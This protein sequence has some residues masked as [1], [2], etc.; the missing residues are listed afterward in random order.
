[1]IGQYRVEVPGVHRPGPTLD[2]LPDRRFVFG[3]HGTPLRLSIW[4]LCA[5][6]T[7]RGEIAD[8]RYLVGEHSE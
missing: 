4:T 2:Q 1:M 5:S 3:H 8:N 7:H 6:R